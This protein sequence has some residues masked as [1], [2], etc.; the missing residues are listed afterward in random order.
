MRR[1][2]RKATAVAPIASMI[3]LTAAGGCAPLAQAPLVYSSKNSYG[4]DISATSTETP[5]VSF[6]I[7]VKLVDAAYVPVAVAV[8]CSGPADQGTPSNCADKRFE[9]QKIQGTS[10]LKDNSS[11]LAQ[12]VDK[13][14]GDLDAAT[15][16]VLTKDAAVTQANQDLTTDQVLAAT[17]AAAQLAV[18][19]AAAGSAELAAAQKQLTDA[20][21]AKGQIAAK[22]AVLANARAELLAAQAVKA[23]AQTDYNAAVAARSVTSTTLLTDAYSVFGTFDGSGGGSASTS[24]AAGPGTEGSLSVGKMFSTGIASQNLSTAMRY[25][26]IGACLQRTSKAITDA[27]ADATLS[28]LEKS[29][30][31]AALYMLCPNLADA[32]N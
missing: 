10:T 19:G 32:G 23:T 15:A 13:T 31:V 8:P 17:E 7:G 3:L 25:Q 27:K 9:L 26:L 22:Q 14:K 21:V 4:I 30:T 18:N 6:A 5:G 11:P 24:A 29:R 2:I 28:T 16:I 12:R 20:Q 1:H